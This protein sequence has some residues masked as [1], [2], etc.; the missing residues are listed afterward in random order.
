MLTK[1]LLLSLSRESDRTS[2]TNPKKRELSI[3]CTELP[4]RER[5]GGRGGT[6]EWVGGNGL[7][8]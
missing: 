4:T 8:V 6:V 1:L 3:E 7:S 2:D 5:G